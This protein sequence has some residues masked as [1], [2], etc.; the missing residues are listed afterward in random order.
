MDTSNWKIVQMIPAPGWAA[1]YKTEGKETTEDELVCWALVDDQSSRFVTGMIASN[2]VE[3]LC[4]FAAADSS[5]IRY[6][7]IAIDIATGYGALA[8][9]SYDVT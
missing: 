9:E 4:D 5:F 6:K 7:K 2:E 3:G 8:V 1:V